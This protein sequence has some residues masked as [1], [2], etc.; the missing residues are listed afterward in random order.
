VLVLGS[1]TSSNSNRLREVAAESGADAYL[2]DD[3]SEIQPEWLE[4]CELVG[5][6]AGASAPERLIVE[7]I[8]KLV[9]WGGE[10]VTGIAR[11]DE[12]VSFSVPSPRG[13]R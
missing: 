3:V 13:N 10:L 1:P 5:V 12:G 4:R 11:E 7:V 6:T 2:I 8:D 9:T